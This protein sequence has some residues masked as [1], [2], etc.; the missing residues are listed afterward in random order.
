MASTDILRSV[1]RALGLGS[2]ALRLYHQPL[3]RLRQSFAEGGPLEQRRTE[4]ARLEMIAAARMLP[5]LAVPEGQDSLAVAFLSGAR[6][7][8][9]TLFCVVSLQTHSPFR[10]MPVLYDDGTF[11]EGIW[12]AFSRVVPWARLERAVDI[13][14]R[15]DALLPAARFPALRSRRLVYPHLRKLT[16]IHVGRSGWLAVLDSDM[17]FFRPPRALLDWLI[18]PDRPCSLV[19]DITCYGYSP[20]LMR[21]LAG[22][23]PPERVNVGICGLRSDAVDWDRLEYWC[24]A[25]LERQGSHYFQE[26]ALTAMLMTGQKC[27]RFGPPDYIVL[28]SLAEGRAPTAALHHYV[29][30]SKRSYFRHGWRRVLADAEADRQPWPSTRWLQRKSAREHASDS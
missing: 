24:R 21:E 23:D 12:S 19:E 13:E 11:D 14:R 7:W 6:F 5:P 2:L 25:L 4:Q 22:R 18:A 30:S 29:S 1:S 8:W 9:Q 3:A 16:D 15:L 20:E 26:Q 28:P 27:H 10:I 17:L